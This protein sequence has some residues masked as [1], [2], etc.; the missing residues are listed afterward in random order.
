MLTLK[1]RNPNNPTSENEGK[2][3]RQ[4]KESTKTFSFNIPHIKC[5]ES[6]LQQVL[7]SLTIL[8]NTMF[9]CIGQHNFSF[10][11]YRM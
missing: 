5:K 7:I 3:G 11:I 10:S 4:R 9:I 8:M 6:I 1:L 2:R